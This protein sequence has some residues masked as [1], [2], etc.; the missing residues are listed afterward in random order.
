MT[1]NAQT[2]VYQKSKKNTQIMF[3]EYFYICAG[4]TNLNTA[5]NEKV[6][7]VYMTRESCVSAKVYLNAS[8]SDPLLLL[9]QGLS[10]TAI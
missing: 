9:N 3:F 8:K 7:T 4:K 1:H 2:I 10:T 6:I 5:K